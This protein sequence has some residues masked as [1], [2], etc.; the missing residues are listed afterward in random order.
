[1]NKNY[2]ELLEISNTASAEEIRRS[3]RALAKRHHPDHNPKGDEAFKKLNTAYSTL[4]D[5]SKRKKYDYSIKETL[6]NFYTKPFQGYHH[7]S[8]NG[9]E[10]LTLLNATKSMWTLHIYENELLQGEIMIENPC[11]P[12]KIIRIKLDSTIKNG[13]RW[14]LKNQGII[15]E[16]VILVA[17]ILKSENTQQTST[18]SPQYEDVNLLSLETYTRQSISQFLYDNQKRLISFSSDFIKSKSGLLIQ[19]EFIWNLLLEEI[20]KLIASSERKDEGDNKEK[21][22]NKY[23]LDYSIDELKKAIILTLSTS[24]NSSCT[25]KSLC[26]KVLSNLGLVTRGKPRVQFEKNVL[27][28]LEYLIVDGNVEEYKSKNER[29]KLI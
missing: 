28:A 1:V 14:V 7:Y 29:L 6:D 17:D 12:T 27:K 26:T 20:S 3:Y 18:S 9:F 2:Y 22:Q 24:R 11:R 13:S 23:P 4:I 5:P 10:R 16:D 15:G 19:D 8:K 25:K 21:K